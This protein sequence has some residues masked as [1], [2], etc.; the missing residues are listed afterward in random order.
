ML[1]ASPATSTLLPHQFV[2]ERRL[3]ASAQASFNRAID[4]RGF[5]HEARIESLLGVK[6]LNIARFASTRFM[7]RPRVI[8][9]EKAER[10]RSNAEIGMGHG[11]NRRI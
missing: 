2:A 7:R 6:L 10:A 3:A 11:L 8:P 9:S 4:H 1:G 5:T